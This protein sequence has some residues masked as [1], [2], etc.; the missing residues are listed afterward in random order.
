VIG[1]HAAAV[2]TGA[3]E[4]GNRARTDRRGD[5]AGASRH[6]TRGFSRRGVRKGSRRYQLEQ[7]LGAIV[8]QE[9]AHA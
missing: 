4:N 7:A 5:F 3:I 2:R 8:P 1:D 9:A 6:E